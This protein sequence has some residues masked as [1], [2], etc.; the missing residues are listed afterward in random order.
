MVSTAYYLS[1]L[2]GALILCL[3]VA[4]LFREFYHKPRAR[5][6]LERLRAQAKKRGGF[7]SDGP[8]GLKPTL[9]FQYDNAQMTV[10][11][12]PASGGEAPEPEITYVTFQTTRLQDKDFRLVNRWYKKPLLSAARVEGFAGEFGGSFSVESSDPYFI[13]QLLTNAIQDAL[14]SYDEPLQIVFGRRFGI[15]RSEIEPAAGQF[16][17]AVNGIKFE[18]ADYDWLIN[19]AVLFYERL[20]ALEQSYRGA[21][22]GRIHPLSEEAK[23]A[24]L[25]R[26]AAA[27][28]RPRV[29]PETERD[30]I[31]AHCGYQARRW[32][33]EC[34]ECGRV[35]SFRETNAATKRS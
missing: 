8:S 14:L 10:S 7:L 11:I 15:G 6:V 35:N 30:C 9:S 18:D 29:A 26:P 3:A 21:P 24:P 12:L 13:R 27:P 25:S 33:E 32:L 31:C 19:T 22:G 5:K 34:P 23:A 1:L 17:I 16:A 4:W 2:L 20:K 28:L